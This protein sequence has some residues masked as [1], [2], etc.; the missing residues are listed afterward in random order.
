MFDAVVLEYEVVSPA[1]LASI[2]ER[3]AG[4]V[5]NWRDVRGGDAFRLWVMGDIT[6]EQSAIICAICA[7]Y[8]WQRTF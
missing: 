3:R 4:V 5:C 7:R 1:V 2:I 8:N 6:P